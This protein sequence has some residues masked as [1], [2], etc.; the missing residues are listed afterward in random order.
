[1]SRVFNFSAGPATLPEEVL[2]EAQADMLDWHGRGWSIMETSHRGKDFVAIQ[3]DTEAR[4][5]T[6]LGVPEDYEVLLLQGGGHLQFAMVPINLLGAGTQADYIVNGAWSSKAA[7]EARR[8]CLARVAGEARNRAPQQAELDLDPA[9]AYVH[10][11]SNETVDGIE[12]DYV[13][14]TGRVP[15]VADMS[16]HFLSRPVDV[17]R[18]G[19]IYAGAQ[20]NFGPAG[21]TVVIV[22]RDLLGMCGKHWPSMLDYKVHARAGSA[23]NTPPTYSIYIAHLVLQWLER[24]GGVAGIEAVNLEKSRL[25]YDAIDGSGGFYVNNVDRACRSRM[26]VTFRLAN[27]ALEAEWLAGAE[28]RGLTQLKGHRSVGGLRASIYNAMPLAGVRALVDYL[29]DFARSHG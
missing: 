7:E 13:P 22:Q 6:L 20:K 2:R 26:N 8:F 18:Y 17:S 5:R 24:Q 10:Y 14:E 21:L 25:L 4:L 19:L 9:S 3:E 27:E 29:Q 23:Y 12:F 15:L 16:S 11:C 1:M 28:A